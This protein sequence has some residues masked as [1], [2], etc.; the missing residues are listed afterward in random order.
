MLANVDDVCFVSA[1]WNSLPDTLCD[2]RRVSTFYAGLANIRNMSTLEVPPLH[3]FAL[4]RSTFTYFLL[5]DCK[6]QLFSGLCTSTVTSRWQYIVTCASIGWPKSWFAKGME[7]WVL[8][9]LTLMLQ[10][11]IVSRLMHGNWCY[12]L[13]RIEYIPINDIDMNS[14]VRSTALR[15]DVFGQVHGTR[16]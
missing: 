11:C 15:K 16:F 8:T 6:L 2:V 9:S 12:V 14:Y 4:H 10:Y 13:S 1:V 5:S 7:D 3:G